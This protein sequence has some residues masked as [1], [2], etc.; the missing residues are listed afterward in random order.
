MKDQEASSAEEAQYAR[1]VPADPQAFIALYDRYFERV[2]NYVRYRCDEPALCDDLTAMI[3]E[4]AL[5]RIK[6]YRA[7]LGPFGAWLFGIARNAV[8]YNLRV[9]KRQKWQPLD[10]LDDQPDEALTPEQALMDAEVQ[11]ELLVALQH[12]SERERD[13]IGL[14]FAAQLTNRRIAELTGLSESNVGVILYRAI[15]KL[16]AALDF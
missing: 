14:K 1:R 10:D 12:V 4:L 5:T 6:G 9:Q 13:L 3:F 11:D 16:R 7:E 8:N 15:H 2:Y